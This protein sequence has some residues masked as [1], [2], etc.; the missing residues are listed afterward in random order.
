MCQTRRRRRGKK[1]L[2]IKK[3][4]ETCKKTGLILVKLGLLLGEFF[5]HLI[6]VVVLM[7]EEAVPD[8]KLDKPFAPSFLLLI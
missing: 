7:F 2:K 5:I 1:N 4:G 3:K 8:Y 6:R